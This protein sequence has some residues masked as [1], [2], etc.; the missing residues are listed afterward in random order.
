MVYQLHMYLFTDSFF[1][2]SHSYWNLSHLIVCPVPFGS[3]SSQLAFILMQMIISDW[4][5]ED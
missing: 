1:C 3:L 5:Y 2:S 4:N